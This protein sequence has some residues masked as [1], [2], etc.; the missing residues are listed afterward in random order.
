MVENIYIIKNIYILKTQRWEIPNENQQ[1]LLGCK[2][3]VRSN[4]CFQR[5]GNGNTYNMQEIVTH[6]IGKQRHIYHQNLQ[7][8]PLDDAFLRFMY[9]KQSCLL[10]KISMCIPVR[11]LKCIFSPILWIIMLI[12]R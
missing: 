3:S 1:Y 10:F 4:I 7:M 5:L 12:G 2:K 6:Y 8:K 9:V 11:S